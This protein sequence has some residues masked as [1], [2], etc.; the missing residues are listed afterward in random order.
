L[1]EFRA[2]RQFGTALFSGIGR[3]TAQDLPECGF[4]PSYPGRNA[5]FTFF[6]AFVTVKSAKGAA[7]TG[8]LKHQADPKTPET[9]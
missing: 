4:H 7:S 8:A 6:A 9:F 1:S 5:G 3:P 2:E